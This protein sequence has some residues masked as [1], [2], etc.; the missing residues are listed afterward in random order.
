MNIKNLAYWYLLIGTSYGLTE[1]TI[2][3]AKQGFTPLEIG[4]I[5]VIVF[6][7]VCIIFV[8]PYD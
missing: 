3:L 2:D 6:T 4:T 8:R 1:R 7:L 5:A